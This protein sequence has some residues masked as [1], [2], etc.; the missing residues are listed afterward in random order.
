MLDGVLD[1]EEIFI[2][3]TNKW[4]APLDVICDWITKAWD[5]DVNSEIMVHS[6]KNSD[7]QTP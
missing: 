1:G 7:F 2:K 3:S 5:D 4:Y 6:F